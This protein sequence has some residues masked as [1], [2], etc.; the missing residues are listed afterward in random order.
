MKVLHILAL[1]AM[2]IDAQSAPWSTVQDTPLY[3]PA[4]ELG[5]G[6]SLQ[7]SGV[8]PQSDQGGDVSLVNTQVWT[9]R[10]DGPGGWHDQALLIAVDGAGSVIVAGDSF[11]ASTGSDFAVVKYSGNGT[12]LWTNRFSGPGSGGFWSDLCGGMVLDRMGNVYVSGISGISNYVTDVVTLK[13]SSNGLPLWT[14]RFSTSATNELW[15]SDIVIDRSGNTF[16]LA[17]DYAFQGARDSLVAYNA[18]GTALWTNLHQTY[19]PNANFAF[20]IATDSTGAVIVGGESRQLTLMLARYGP[21]GSPGS[22]FE[23]NT[24][25]LLRQ[26]C[27]DRLDNIIASA[28]LRWTGGTVG[29]LTAK[30]ANDFTLLWTNALP[31][32]AYSGGSVPQHAIDYAGS[33]FTTGGSAGANSADAD[34]TTVKFTSAGIPVWT[35]RFLYNTDGRRDFGG[36]VTD[37]AGNSFVLL[38]SS[39]PGQSDTDFVLLK[40]TS[41][42]T[43]VWTNRFDG[44]SDD[45]ANALAV[46]S[47]GS[48]F[49]TGMSGPNWDPSFLTIKYSDYVLY[50]PPRGFVGTDSI[51]FTAVDMFGSSITGQVSVTV[52][53]APLRLSTVAMNLEGFRMRLEG[54]ATTN[55]T[56]ILASSNL[57][58]WTAIA[59]NP[60]G[61]TEFTDTAALNLHQ[62]FYKATSGIESSPP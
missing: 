23:H 51:R 56:V 38:S 35:N 34:F 59:T 58:H 13:Y 17:H 24:Q 28:E 27:V 41:N 47:Q 57:V 32:P 44:G 2:A 55:T 39:R 9:A 3:F 42:G 46:D 52:S 8:L 18:S 5:A 49:V 22:A 50:T 40:L 20:A 14:N 1:F 12:T 61:A 43:P 15:L 30:F 11:G 21:D 29:Y 53:P 7:I 36:T 31:G 37:R 60:P 26:M 19:F 45:Y 25:A 62:R 10:Y 16:L 6:P 4:T 54:S 48:V 33:V